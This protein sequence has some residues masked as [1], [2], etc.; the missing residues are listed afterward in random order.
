MNQIAQALTRLYERHRIIFWY[1]AKL[2]LRPEFDALALPDIEKIV[3]NNNQFGVKYRILRQEPEQKFLLYQAGPAP[4]EL[5][6][7]L[8]DVELAHTRFHADQTALWLSELGLP[9]EFA[10]EIEPHLNFFKAAQADRRRE[11]LKKLLQPDDPPY[12]VR[13]KM[14]A[15]CVGSEPRLDDIV[16]SLLG[17]LAGQKEEKIKLIER[18]A[19]TPFLW[20]QMART[21]GYQSATPS[22]RDFVLV[23][24]KACYLAG[25]GEPAP[26]TND[27][28]VFLKRW[29]DN[30]HHQTAFALLSVECAKHLNIEQDLAGR[31]LSEL[32]E[33][34]LFDLI[35]RKILSDL[36]REVA[37][38]TIPV[39]TAAELIRQR[40]LSHWYQHHAHT[41]GAVEVAA[42][43]LQLL[44]KV[45]LT[46]RSLVDGIQQYSRV[47][48]AVDQCYRQFIYHM[49]QA[50]QMTLLAP[51]WER[52]ENL[53][54]NNYLLPLNHQWQPWLDRCT[55]WEAAPILAQSEFYKERVQP[56]LARNNKIFVII[57]DALRY[58]IGEELLHLIR[59]EDRYEATLEPALS[60]LP[61]FTQL[62]MAALLPHKT[63]TLAGDKADSVVVDGNSSQGTENRKKI[64]EK[65]LPGRATALLA[66]ELL[67]MSRE[68]SRALFRDYEVVYIYHNRI[69]ATG[70]KRDSEERV[71]D[72]AAET[73]D[74]L[75][76]I[77]KKLAN[78]NVSNM[79]I[80]AD[81]GFLY[82]HRPLEES[83]FLSQEPSGAQIT[84]INRRFV[85]G[86]GLNKGAGFTHFT[87]SAVGLQGQ[88]ELLL[89]KSINRL[90]VQGAGS[91]YVHGGASLQEV[92]IPV[93][94]INKKRQSDVT[95]VEVDI[96]RSATA[97]ITAGQL[98]VAFYQTEPVT[99]KVQPRRLRAGIY[100]QA[101]DL[102]SDEH[103]LAFNLTAD[104]AREREI[105][106]QFVLTKKADAANNQD[107]LL[108][109]RE[110]V[111][112]TNHWSDYKAARYLLRRSFTSDFDD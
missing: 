12:Q 83:D 95:Q 88:T 79:L 38:R 28:L 109:L 36:V 7:W 81:H 100:T 20:E 82:Q 87:A 19:L 29:K 112:D 80:T 59:Q 34:D 11:K 65:A 18:C 54:T 14:L 71:F 22:L 5:D 96:I 58:E 23:L 26:L 76:K 9:P 92:V 64:L 52:I 6:N 32:A 106:V 45:D 107:V 99:E 84:T 41:Y 37:N 57:S 44:D 67:A 10:K 75:I 16:E 43:F 27:A 17:E 103:E 69:D 90:R 24:F 53:Y 104:H 101:G 49:R 68:Q 63:L 30:V 2:E 94:Q 4:D 78:A 72:E 74:E 3:L 35:D 89:P 105:R 40:R 77:I 61:S 98:T 86:R 51:L 25:L 15:V 108:R 62:G 47:W 21:Y 91:R 48:F 56:F 70:D 1:D 60:V 42:R 93:I 66:T 13:L 39:N 110:Q 31:T 33:L 85:L 8:L 102:I 55:Q 111:A 73:L 46:I 50:D 97:T